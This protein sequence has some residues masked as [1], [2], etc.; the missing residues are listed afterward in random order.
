[1][2]A[3]KRCLSCEELARVTKELEAARAAV[4]ESWFSG[5]VPLSEAIRRKTW[6]MDR[7]AHAFGPKEEA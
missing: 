5:G 2:R 1:M 4:G 6:M 3:E 7:L